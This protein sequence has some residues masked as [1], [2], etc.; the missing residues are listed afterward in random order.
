MTVVVE[1][2]QRLSQREDL[3][4][5][6][7]RD[8]M[9]QIMRGEWTSAQIGAF[10]LGLRV[11]R[12]SLTELRELSTRVPVNQTKHLVDTCGTGGDAKHTFNISTA[13]AFVV[14]AAGGRVAKHGGRAASSLSGSA[15][16]LESLGVPLDLSPER[17]AVAIDTLGIGFMFAAHHHPAMKHV[18]SIRRELGVRT[19]FNVLG[20]LTNPAGATSQL[21]GV[22]SGALVEPLARVL[23]RLGTQHALVV[24]GTDGLDEISISAPT[25]LGEIKNG[26]Y[27]ER[28]ITPE[29]FGFKSSSLDTLIVDSLAAA[30]ESLLAVLEN[31]PDHASKRDIVLLNAGA[32]LYVCAVAESIED[33]IERAR[34]ALF[35]GAARERLAGLVAFR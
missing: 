4:A 19:L 18:G 6:Q 22:F 21:L 20:P 30:R 14:A 10:M 34:N 31:R 35:S 15:D 8:V 12:E 32:A 5:E 26:E 2:L 24:A 11:K 7:M 13:V 17:I 16:V 9:H 29:E 1:V 23:A 3:S 33:G 25:L 28:L 27:Q